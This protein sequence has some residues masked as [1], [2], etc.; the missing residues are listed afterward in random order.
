MNTTEPN[1]HAQRSAAAA[2]L[3]EETAALARDAGCAESDAEALAKIVRKLA[4][5]VCGNRETH[6]RLVPAREDFAF[7]E[8]TAAEPPLN[9]IAGTPASYAAGAPTRPPP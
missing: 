4:E 7:L 6:L 3:S 1:Q 2:W 8:K 5:T 9:R